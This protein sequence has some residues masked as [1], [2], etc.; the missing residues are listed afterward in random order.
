M[1]RRWTRISKRSNVAVPAPQGDFL[2]V[3]LSFRVGNGI[4]PRITTPAR[5]VISLIDSIT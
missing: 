3:T 4:G 2:V 1:I 5:W